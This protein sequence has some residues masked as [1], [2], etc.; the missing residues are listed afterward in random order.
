MATQCLPVI[1]IH[2]VKQQKK[3]FSE[4]VFATT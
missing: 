1:G 2:V 4:H 3:L